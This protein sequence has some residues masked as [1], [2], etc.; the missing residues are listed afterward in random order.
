MGAYSDTEGASDQATCAPY[1]HPE[2]AEP[3]FLGWHSSWAPLEHVSKV[4]VF[5]CDDGLSCRGLLFTYESGAQRALGQCRLQVDKC[6][7]YLSPSRF[8]SLST[9]TLQPEWMEVDCCRGL[10]I[11][12]IDGHEHTGSHSEDSWKCFSMTGTLYFY[13][14]AEEAVITVEA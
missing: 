9:T 4:H 7:E 14:S 6:R 12:F 10:Q 5:Y 11:V 1:R 13:F 2:K 3:P 8:C